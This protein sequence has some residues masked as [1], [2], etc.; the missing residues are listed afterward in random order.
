MLGSPTPNA[1]NP[2]IYPVPPSQA[3]YIQELRNLPWVNQLFQTIWAGADFRLVDIDQLLAF[4][5]TVDIERSR[6]HCGSV[7]APPSESDIFRI[8]LPLA[9]EPVAPQMLQ[10]PGALMLKA[11]NGNLRISGFGLY[12]IVGGG[13]ALGIQVI[14]SPTF[15]HVVR[16]DG[17]C[18]LHNGFHRAVGLMRAGATQMACV[19]REVSNPTAIGIREDKVTF[20][21]ALLTGTNPPTLAHYSMGRAY[22]VTL[23]ATTRLININWSE[24]MAAED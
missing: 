14:V 23:R 6:H 10:A 1:G 11:R 2:G 8:C 22:D 20:G 24:Y 21:L 12:D 17:R 16:Y 18:Y 5:Q 13:K 9:D 4:Q 15:V 3:A 7:D 19:Y